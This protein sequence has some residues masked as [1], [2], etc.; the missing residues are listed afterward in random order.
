[1]RSSF[2][3]LPRPSIV[4]LLG[5]ISQLQDRCKYFFI[6]KW[7]YRRQ[8]YR[9][10][11]ALF[12][13]LLMPL[14][15][16][17]DHQHLHK[18]LLTSS[19]LRKSVVADEY[20]RRSSILLIIP[21]IDF[22]SS[23]IESPNYESYFMRISFYFC[24][25][26]ALTSSKADCICLFCMALCSLKVRIFFSTSLFLINKFS[27]LLSILSTLFSSSPLTCGLAFLMVL[28]SWSLCLPKSLDRYH[29]WCT[30]D[31]CIRT[32]NRSRSRGF[33]PRGATRRSYCLK[34]Q[35][36]AQSLPHCQHPHKRIPALAASH[37]SCSCWARPRA[38]PA[39]WELLFRID[40]TVL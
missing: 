8:H 4:Y 29:G 27:M 37:S 10:F 38:R 18:S 32:C 2:S 24:A 13:D 15:I 9:N 16:E 14:R 23:S 12:I 1:M 39:T 31:R 40:H 26:L 6:T 17:I 25:N 30:R 20:P 5:M 33:P 21:F 3:I 34:Y 35:S 28:T 22:S 19:R 11:L 7:R 36:S